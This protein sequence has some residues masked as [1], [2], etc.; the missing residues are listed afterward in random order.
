MGEGGGEVA[1]CNTKIRNTHTVHTA[2]HRHNVCL[3]SFFLSSSS[4]FSSSS[5]KQN[6]EIKDLHLYAFV[7]AG[8]LVGCGLCVFVSVFFCLFVLLNAIYQLGKF[9]DSSV[10]AAKPTLQTLFSYQ[11]LEK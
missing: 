8:W 7:F 10:E 2:Q 9:S 11:F 5:F 1:L 6:F 3:L 4:S